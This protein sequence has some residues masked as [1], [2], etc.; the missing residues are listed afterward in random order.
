MEFRTS[1]KQSSGALSL[2]LIGNDI[3][4][5]VLGVVLVALLT[6]CATQSP[7]PQSVTS[8]LYWP[9][10]P[11][12]PRYQFIMSFDDSNDIRT[13]SRSLRL[14]QFLS[15]PIR[16]DYVL[17]RPLD[18]AVHQ[19]RIYVLDSVS[20]LVH[21][22]DLKRRRYFRFGYRFEGK[23]SKPVAIC[24]DAKG[25]VYVS[26]RGRGAV[27]VYDPLGLYIRHIDLAD[28]VTQ[29][30]GIAVS[31]DGS[32]IYLVDRGGID[33]ESH[34]VLKLSAD[35]RLLKRIGKRGQ[36]LGE[37]NLPNDIVLNSQGLLYVLDSGN[38]RVQVLDA[39]GTALNA[40]GSAG[41]SFGQFGIPKSITI[42]PQDLIYVSDT[43]FGNVQIF[44][45]QGKLLLP[46]GKLSDQ[47]LPGHYSLISGITFDSAGYL[48][49]LDQYF[50]KI[51]IFKKLEPN[52]AR[53]ILRGY[54]A[55][56]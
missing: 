6:A 37:F 38:F 31:A 53:K 49:V 32:V 27:I 4:S 51:E 20:P 47:N 3:L 30:A 22:F 10:P 9:S 33:S 17:N 39:E 2:Y 16:P 15:G 18:I 29:P 28:S 26:D 21:V 1:S 48:Y 45:A 54:S 52:E 55:K 56:R 19:G 12:L 46:L 35:G 7:A 8:R 40:W 14:R 24:V 44:D 36:A 42:D 34:Q 11:E 23:L 43:Q 25:W 41:D 5:R 50:N 13:Q